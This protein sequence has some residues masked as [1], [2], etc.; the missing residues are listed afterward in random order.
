MSTMEHKDNSCHLTL[1][2]RLNEWVIQIALRLASCWVIF[3]YQFQLWTAYHASI[4][5]FKKLWVWVYVFEDMS[6]F[7]LCVYVCVSVCL[8]VFVYVYVCVCVSVCVYVCVCLC[9]YL[10]V[11]VSMC[12]CVSVC[13]CMDV[14]IY[15]CVYIYIYTHIHTH[16]IYLSMC[17]CLCVFVC[18]LVCV[19]LCACLHVLFARVRACVCVW[20]GGFCLPVEDRRRSCKQPDIGTRNWTPVLG[21]PNKSFELSHRLSCFY[22]AFSLPHPF[23]LLST[24]VPNIILH[25]I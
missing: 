8:C 9:V 23:P 22:H 15:L 25:L 5:L 17:V 13:V 21:K 20:G 11:Y 16:M 10:C 1:L 14:C 3:L 4:F 7:V 12:V 18:M 6:V 24:L 2:W 19:Y